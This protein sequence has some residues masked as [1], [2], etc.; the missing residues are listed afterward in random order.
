MCV[1][2]ISYLNAE[3]IIQLDSSTVSSIVVQDFDSSLTTPE[4]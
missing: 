2:L 3:A 1:T 4:V